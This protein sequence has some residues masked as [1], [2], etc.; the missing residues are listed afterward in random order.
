MQGCWNVGD[1]AKVK[2]KRIRTI[3]GIGAETIE[4]LKKKGVV[5]ENS[6]PK[7]RTTGIKYSQ[8][9]EEICKMNQ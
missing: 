5:F 9:F 1:F 6:Q 4:K 3:G 8:I 7:K 2:E